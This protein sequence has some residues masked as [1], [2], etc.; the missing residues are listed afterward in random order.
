M[1][2]VLAAAVE[3]SLRQG[4]DRDV[5]LVLRSIGRLRTV[6]YVRVRNAERRTVASFGNGVVVARG[7]EAG[8]GKTVGPFELFNLA[9]F[10]V[11]VPIV[12]SG[13]QIGD[14]TLIANVSELRTAFVESLLAAALIGLGASLLAF[15][16]AL[17]LQR[18]VSK[19]LRDLASAMRHVRDTGNYAGHVQRASSDETGELVDSFNAMLGEIRTRDRALREHSETLEKTVEERTHDLAT[20]KAAAEAANEAKSE[21]L[22]TMSHEI[23]TPMNGMLV[24]AELL[25]AGGLDAKLQRYA[26]VIV[27]SG[28]G[29]LAIIN[30]ILDLS[31]IEAGHLELECISV[32]P[33]SIAEDVARLFGE[34]AASKGLDLAVA[35]EP[36]VPRA[37]GAD[38]VRCNQILSN[39]TNNALKFTHAGG[40][41][42]TVSSLAHLEAGKVVL[43]FAVSDTGIGISEEKIASIFDAFS[44]ADS[45]TMREYG[46]TGI[47]L[48]ICRRLV[49]AMGGSILVDSVVGSGTTFTVEIPCEIIGEFAPI[50]APIA[51]DAP[52]IG[53]ALPQGPT[54]AALVSAARVLELRTIDIDPEQYGHVAEPVV[55]LVAD[56]SRIGQARR[57]FGDSGKIFSVARFGDTSA[58]R[59]E[60]S[61]EISGSIPWPVTTSDAIEVLSR[62]LARAPSVTHQTALTAERSRHGTFDGLRVLAADD[63]AINREVLT[64][65]LTRLQVDVVSVANGQQAIDLIEREA[66]DLV[67]MDASM[68]VLNGFQATRVIRNWEQATGRPPVPIIA[69]TAHVVGS[70]ANEWV[71]AGMVDCVTKPFT[72][73]SIEA[74]LRKWIPQDRQKSNFVR[75]NVET[76]TVVASSPGGDLNSSRPVL[77][78]DVLQSIAELAGPT[79]DLMNRL[80]GLFREHSPVALERLLTAIDAG[81]PAS[82]ASAA[83][84]FKSMCRNIGAIELGRALHEIEEAAVLHSSVPPRATIGRLS[85]SL[86]SL[87]AALEALEVQ[88]DG[89]RTTAAA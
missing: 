7:G 42:I 43:R 67:F 62:A 49:A 32:A 20:A 50:P 18:F 44:Q 53:L 66:F 6:T 5:G 16:L 10:P 36:D 87:L 21:F 89:D 78:P 80:V 23:R 61:G 31:K 82:I 8:P 13:Q 9:A 17:W 41:T 30:D 75:G 68:P 1:A 81:D 14:L 27:K 74:C 12:S 52:C 24:M 72:L 34:R 35:V 77:D 76:G 48:T 40:V 39:L 84:A 55:A 64:E 2:N 45:S 3:P 70:R 37:I 54:H 11:Q 19:P 33:A 26:D 86:A 69:L 4:V 28:H 15:L 56:V 63:S 60:Q 85:E 71:D 22:A 73:A 83:H 51:S 58:S 47:G 65:A 88:S 57:R 46:G 59:L 79:S 25:S 29:L 38:P